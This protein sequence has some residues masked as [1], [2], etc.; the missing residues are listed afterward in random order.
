MV[1]GGQD[2]GVVGDQNDGA[3]PGKVGNDFVFLGGRREGSEQ[4]GQEKDRGASRK[5]SHRGRL[6]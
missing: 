3:A 1:D 2:D 4:R 5:G 6:A